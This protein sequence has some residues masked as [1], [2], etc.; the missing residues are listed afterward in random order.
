MNLIEIYVFT[1]LS[2]HV[3]KNCERSLL[4]IYSLDHILLGLC[5]DSELG[6][7]SIKCNRS[8]R[9]KQVPKNTS[10]TDL[11]FAM[12]AWK[13]KKQSTKKLEC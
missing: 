8:Q 3:S 4:F 13:C 10:M 11:M 5:I 9:V 7:L 1:S 2:L 6:Y 12:N